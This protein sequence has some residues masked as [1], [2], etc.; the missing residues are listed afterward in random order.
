MA[1]NRAYGQPCTPNASSA[2]LLQERSG[3]AQASTTLNKYSHVRRDLQD[4]G[5]ERFGTALMAAMNERPELAEGVGFEPTR[6][7]ATPGG[8]QVRCRVL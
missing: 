6:G 2:Q 4:E 5:A 1:Y 3:H 8:F 7:L